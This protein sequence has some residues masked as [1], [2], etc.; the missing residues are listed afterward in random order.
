MRAGINELDKIGMI[1][2]AAQK[3]GP[4]TS[5]RPYV[6]NTVMLL[7]SGCLEHSYLVQFVETGSIS[8]VT[9]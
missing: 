9:G 2:H 1:S 6:M 8:V 5:Q 7:M 3:R 4:N